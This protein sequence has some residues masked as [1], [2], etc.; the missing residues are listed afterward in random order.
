MVLKESTM[1]M[2][3]QQQNQHLHQDYQNLSSG[4][5]HTHHLYGN[6]GV[7]NNNPNHHLQYPPTTGNHIQKQLAFNQLHQ[8]GQS[9]QPSQQQQQSQYVKVNI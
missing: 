4:G 9:Q 6:T 3:Q 7:A 2:A 1:Y 8:Y 5:H